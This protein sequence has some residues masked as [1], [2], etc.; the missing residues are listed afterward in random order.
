MARWRQRIKKADIH[1]LINGLFLMKSFK[2]SFSQMKPLLFSV[3]CVEAF[4]DFLKQEEIKREITR[5]DDIINYGLKVFRMIVAKVCSDLNSAKSTTHSSYNKMDALREYLSIDE[6]YEDVYKVFESEMIQK[7]VHDDT[8][9]DLYDPWIFTV[10]GLI[11]LH[12]VF[13]NDSKVIKYVIKFLKVLAADKKEPFTEAEKDV[14]G[15]FET[16]LVKFKN[17]DE[18]KKK[19]AKEIFTQ[20]FENNAIEFPMYY[21]TTVYYYL[22][23]FRESLKEARKYLKYL[24]WTHVPNQHVECKCLRQE[25]KIMMQIAWIH[26]MRGKLSLAIE[27]FKKVLEDVEN[28]MPKYELID[29]IAREYVSDVGSFPIRFATSI[30]FGQFLCAL[31]LIKRKDFAAA[32]IYLNQ[33]KNHIALL[34]AHN[35]KFGEHIFHDCIAERTTLFQLD[36]KTA[37][38]IA[39]CDAEISVQEMYNVGNDE[40][41]LKEIRLKQ[42]S[43][44]VCL[45]LK[46]LSKQQEYETNLNK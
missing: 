43:N 6:Q 2:N 8:K 4:E 27:T 31:D 7:T 5:F 44:Y 37:Y 15:V 9:R 41:G 17:V 20:L 30:P 21:K 29:E 35:F 38:L 22:E 11:T 18:E 36:T 1:N 28:E 3:K 45:H 24:R 23:D 19:H 13:K 16:E 33:F 39:L 26:F 46:Y 25:K 42:N 14:F 12:K 32:K 40:S 34:M 10:H